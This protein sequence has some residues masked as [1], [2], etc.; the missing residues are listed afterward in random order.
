[1]VPS[2]IRWVDD[3]RIEGTVNPYSKEGGLW[4]IV[5][6]NPDGQVSTL[7]DA[8]VVNFRVPAQLASARIRAAGEGV[9]LEYMLIEADADE[10]FRLYR[11]TLPSEEYTLLVDDL[12]LDSDGILGF[13]DNSVEP[14]RTYAYLLES[15]RADGSVRELHRGSATV[16]A[17]ALRLDPNHPNPFN[18][19]TTIPFY[20]PERTRVRMDVFDVRGAHVTTLASGIFS[21]GAHRVQWNGVDSSGTPAASGVYYLRLRA[22]KRTLQRKMLLLK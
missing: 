11:A 20:L 15:Y 13:S 6:T 22:G 14:G 21:A 10:R 9:R 2:S 16:A 5:V 1:M 3:V 18:P 17:G 12:S 19:L 4:D 8:V 7:E